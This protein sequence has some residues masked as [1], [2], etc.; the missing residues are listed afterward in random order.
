MDT[1]KKI[2]IGGV[3]IAIIAAIVIVLVLSQKKTSSSN[4]NTSNVTN[5]AGVNTRSNTTGTASGGSKPAGTASGGSKP[6]GTAS[7]GTTTTTTTGTPITSTATSGKYY[8]YFPNQGKYL[9]TTTLQLEVDPTQASLIYWN[10]STS[11]I[12]NG[13]KSTL[14][15]EGVT[16]SGAVGPSSILAQT[17]G[18]PSTNSGIGIVLIANNNSSPQTF[19]PVVLGTTNL[20]AGQEYYTSSA[21]N[22]PSY[23]FQLAQ[24]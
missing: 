10:P 14:T 11:V 12:S 2:I 9:N 8:L 20:G 24:P 3:V 19:F 13:D 22:D 1:K 5:S 4:N 6:A 7:G 23:V 16:V 21:L 17:K 18:G 15:L